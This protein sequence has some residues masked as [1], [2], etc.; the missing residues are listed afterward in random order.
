[1]I[2]RELW[3]R[4]KASN[5]RLTTFEERWRQAEETTLAFL[6][7][8][9]VDKIRRVAREG[10]LPQYT[11]IQVPYTYAVLMAAHTYFTSVFLGRNPVLQYTGRHGEPMQS[12][13]AVEALLDYQM[14]VGQMLGPIY[15]WL[16]DAGK[17]GM[18][19]IGTYWDERFENISSISEQ[20][21]ID[22]VFGTPTGKKIKIRETRRARVYSGNRVYNVQPW[23][24]LFDVRFPVREFQ[25]G[26]YAGVRRKLGWNE[27]KRREA[28]G[29]Y[30]N[31]QFLTKGDTFDTQ[32]EQLGT[33]QLQRPEDDQPFSGAEITAMQLNHPTEV[34]T[35]EMCIELIPSEWRL[36]SSSFPEKW[37]FT[38]NQDASV[39]LGAQ[40]HGAFHCK[41]PYNVLTIEPEGYGLIPR[42]MPT[43]L[44]PIQETIDWLLNSHFY[45]VRAALNNKVVVDPSRVVMKDVLDPLP[46]GV[47]RLKPEA[48]G[49]DSRLAM[50]Q[51]QV[52]DVTRTHLADLQMMYGM[53][54]RTVGVNDQ[55]MGMLA[56]GGRKTATEIRTSTSFGVNRLKTISEYMSATGF[57]PL[58]QM[59]L[60]NTQQYYDEE[61][62]FR[63]AGDLATSAGASFMVVTPDIITGFYNYVP[64]DGTLPIDKYALAS[65]WKELMVQVRQMPDI[66][67][68]Y[69][70]GRMFEWVA[71]LAGLKNITQFRTQVVPDPQLLMQ[72]KLGNVVPMTNGR[73]PKNRGASSGVPGGGFNVPGGALNPDQIPGIG[74]VL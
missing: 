15:T 57:D 2:I 67:L 30:T 66:A 21:E 5:K 20:E 36:G 58:S 14:L 28:Q 41:F 22:P 12:V 55:I 42:G 13:Q 35:Y 46:G 54:E 32:R 18:G 16:Y 72:A 11:T 29:Y 6:P 74:P 73:P 43:T 70:F 65:L 44:K 68:Q 37:M 3:S 17:Y 7:E 52:A 33:E 40:P 64:V 34:G 56:T 62:K 51:M 69:D 63:I 10:G 25:R 26:E 27:V 53:G 49:T 23:D 59:L 39:L 1:M 8:R 4:I 45:N 71:Q 48:Y 19:V 9:E 61:Q 31:V 24:F 60:Q 38:C 50:H 47:I